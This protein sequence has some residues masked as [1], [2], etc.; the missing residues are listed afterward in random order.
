[1]SREFISVFL[2]YS[3]IGLSNTKKTISEELHPTVK[4]HNFEKP[5]SELILTTRTEGH[6]WGTN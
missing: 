3:Y 2:L 5:L 1:M 6:H 4:S